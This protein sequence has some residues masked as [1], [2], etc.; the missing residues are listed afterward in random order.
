M[1]SCHIKSCEFNGNALTPNPCDT[2][3]I[4]AI[5]CRYV[6]SYITEIAKQAFC[7]SGRS[8]LFAKA[9]DE[10][11]CSKCKVKESGELTPREEVNIISHDLNNHYTV[12]IGT[13]ELVGEVEKA[14][15]LKIREHY[16]RSKLLR[17]YSDDVSACIKQGDI[18]VRIREY[19]KAGEYYAKAI[20]HVSKGWAKELNPTD[21]Q[22]KSIATTI[23]NLYVNLA[24]T[25]NLA[26][27]F[28]N[29][30][31]NY[32]KALEVYP[33]NSKAYI[34]RA[35]AHKHKKDYDKAIQ[36]C[37][38]AIG[39]DPKNRWFYESRAEVYKA[40]CEYDNAI[41]DYSQILT[42]APDDYRTYHRRGR[43]YVRQK[44]Y[45]KAIADYSSAIRKEPDACNYLSRAILYMAL[46]R[47]ADAIEDC[48]R[49]M[50]AHPDFADCYRIR[51]FAYRKSR[52]RPEAVLDRERYLALKEKHMLD[53][54]ESSLKLK[55]QFKEY[56]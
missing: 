11:I 12:K 1:T 2:C 56:L 51:S 45:A 30:L 28:D 37:S 3:H 31:Y 53:D 22:Q 46:R 8:G 14:K 21:P 41:Q 23:S 10:D 47:Y 5:D 17:I 34:S 55:E 19:K 39:I 7:L 48:F 26:T 29:A 50:E 4:K 24:E 44:E 52:R 38:K 16:F 49:V 33:T 27:E 35:M 42:I 40:K 13:C 25:Y 20:E 36:D 43:M 9:T 15:T 54:R 6:T 32:S 18:G